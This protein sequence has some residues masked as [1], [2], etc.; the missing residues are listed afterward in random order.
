[1]ADLAAGQLAGLRFQAHRFGMRA[2]QAA[3]CSWFTVFIGLYPDRHAAGGA[4]NNSWI[5]GAR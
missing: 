5:R 2:E 4:Q 3:A 1:M